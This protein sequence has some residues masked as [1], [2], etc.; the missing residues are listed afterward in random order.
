MYQ[1]IQS[2]KFMKV[3][4]VEDSKSLNETLTIVLEREGYEVTSAFD[5]LQGLDYALT[6]CFDIII[7]DVMMPKLNGFEVIKQLREKQNFTPV[8][9]LTALSQE[10][11]KVEGLNLG[12]DDYIAKP[13]STLELLA[14]IRALL[15]LCGSKNAPLELGN[16]KLVEHDNIMQTPAKNIR[17][18][19]KEFELMKLLLENF[20]RV[21]KKDEIISSIWG[22]EN[23]CG[24]NSLEVFISFLRKKLSFIQANVSINVVRGVGYQ[25]GITSDK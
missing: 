17:L 24:S 19:T 25:I 7:L 6:R 5:G 20:T 12:A 11:N 15:R 18:S 16:I 2:E 13:F 21:V 22:Y 10:N 23:D 9:M 3:L 14:R 1:V 4:L 8:I